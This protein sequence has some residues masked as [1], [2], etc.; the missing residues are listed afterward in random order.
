LKRA[1]CDDDVVACSFL[2]PERD[3][4]YLLPPSIADWLLEDHL[5][6]FVL[7]ALEEMDL[8]P[9]YGDDRDEGRGGVAHHRKAMVALLLSAYCLGVRSFCQIERACQVDVAFGSSALGC[10]ST[11]RRSPG[12]PS[13]TSRP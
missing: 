1:S 2:A 5:A 4:L 10:S 12:S 13:A 6:F 7:D 9:F 8:S 11:T 3:Q